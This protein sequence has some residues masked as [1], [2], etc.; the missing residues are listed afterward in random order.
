[1]KPTLLLLAQLLAAP[2]FAA[3]VPINIGGTPLTIPAP[4]GFVPVTAG[5]TAMNQ[6]LE[7]VVVPQ[8]VRFVS[9]I[10]EEFLPAVQRGEILGIARNLSVQTA[11]STVDRTITVSDFAELKDVM[12]KQNADMMKKIESE[13][14]G[15]MD[16]IN[17]KIE[18][19]F[20]VKL[21]LSLAGMVP[22]P[23]HEDTDRT[24]AFSMLVSYAMKMP[25]GTPTNFSGTVTATF[26]RAKGKL[27]FTYV[28]GAE[29]DL[30]L[31]RQISKDWAAAILAANPSDAA[32][33]ALESSSSHRFDWGRVW[34][35]AI[36]GGAIG[37]L[38]GL[39]RYFFNRN[40]K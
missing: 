22:L 17:K 12:R 13:M 7:S 28:N 6:A 24:L 29:N 20:D 23:P 2:L 19:Q 3:D 9:F 30:D 39:V 37:G 15:A 18:G 27:F 11:K 21:D 31:T 32:T 34:G 8:N 16:K 35:G 1:M 5:M 26:I 36:I 14:P 33:A 4:A 40:K 10:P 38:Y 25:N